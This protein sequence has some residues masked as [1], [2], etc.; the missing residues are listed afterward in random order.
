MRC[1]DFVLLFYIFKFQKPSV[2]KMMDRVLHLWCLK[3]Y[4]VVLVKNYWLGKHTT[5][6]D[7]RK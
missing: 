7:L 1:V 5:S 3:W 2:Q 4:H 6:E